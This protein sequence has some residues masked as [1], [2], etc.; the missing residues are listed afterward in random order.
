MGVS[1][2]SDKQLN[3]ARL[4]VSCLDR[5]GIVS[6]LSTFLFKRG[7]NIVQSDQYSTDPAG[8]MFFMR[9]EF[10]LH[11]D[12]TFQQMNEQFTEIASQFQLHW[13]LSLARK[14][15]KMAI[16]VSKEDHCLMELLWKWRAGE[17]DVDI[18][19]VIS[20]HPDSKQV[21]ENYGI[22]FYHIPVNKE[23]KLEAETKMMKLL[24]QAEIDFSVLARYMQIL[25]PSFVER[26]PDRIIN[27][28]HSFLPAFIGAN[29]YA[30]AFERGVKLIGATAH[31]VTND[32]DEGPIIEQDV[33]R[34][35]HRYSSDELRV[36]GRNVERTTLARAVRWH[37][38]DQVIVHGNKTIVFSS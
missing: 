8:G 24:Q 26:F 11:E 36:L 17:L 30:K 38:D 28:H 34:S 21:V 14:K 7:A 2:L 19:L 1:T 3:R 32:L 29:P 27:I 33:I 23:N 31:Y 35:H 16:F 12:D 20:N 22:P 5:P 15:K 6:V 9:I 4:L 13:Q 25:S 10:D 18:P 37:I